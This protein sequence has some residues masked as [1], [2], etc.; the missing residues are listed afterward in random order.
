MLA[1]LRYVVRSLLRNRG[2]TLVTVLTLALGIGSAGAIFSATDWILFRRSQM[3]EDVYMVGGQRDKQA[4][5]PVRLGFMV[6]AYQEAMPGISALEVAGNE[7]GNVVVEGQPVDTNWL[8]VSP[9]LLPMLGITTWRGRGFV[10]GDAVAGSDQVIVVSNK[11][12]KEHLGGREDA[13]GRKVRVGDSIC[14]IIGIL[15]EGQEFPPFL[16]RGVYRPLIFHTDPAQPWRYQYFCLARLA[17]GFTREQAQEALRT[18]KFDLPAV[19]RQS[20][21]TDQVVLAGLSE[22][23]NQYA[24]PEIYRMLLAAVGCL[25]GIACLN[26]SNLM[27]VRMLGM[28]RELGIRLALGGGRFHIVRLLLLEGIALAVGSA[29]LGLLV[30]NWIFPLLLTSIGGAGSLVVQ[31]L[32]GSDLAGGNWIHWTLGW[33]AVGVMA[34][35]TALTGLMI[36]VVPALRVL[37]TDINAGLKEGGMVLG[38]SRGL[39]RFRGTLVMLQAAFAVILLAGAG[40]MIRTFENFRKVDL[41][42]NPD[43]LI[44]LA[45]GMPP[46]TAD[47]R[48]WQASLTRWRNLQAEIQHEPG[49]RSVGFGQDVVL[50]GWYYPSVD[51]F[52]PGDQTVKAAMGNFNIGYQ[53]TTGIRLK[54]GRWLDQSQGA[55]ILVNESLARTL[56]PGMENPIGQFVRMKDGNSSAHPELKGWEVVGVVADIRSTMRDPPGNYIYSPEAWGAAAMNTFV[57]RLGREYNPAVADALRRRIYA[58]DPQIVVYWISSI[59][60]RR[61][62]MLWAED[63][64]SSVLRVLAAIA[65][66]LAIVGVFAVMA[67]AVDRRMNEFGVRMA[68]GAMPGDLVKLV[69]GRGLALMVVG[70][71]LGLGG[72]M[73][74]G[75]F[76]SSLLFETSPLDPWVL[77]GVAAVLLAAAVLACLWPARRAAQVDVSRLLRSE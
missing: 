62:Q 76:L 14:V 49:V 71:M 13:L 42:F 41:G 48:D 30:A 72:A 51:L 23:L 17:P 45:I 50:P 66:L 47:G 46:R 43:R 12:W 64:A 34:G 54:R 60:E 27:L 35:L 53:E 56:W 63:K 2:F 22:L 16:Y 4:F 32:R 15:K 25:F 67:Y 26:A 74:L 11:F 37:R 20:M 65:L 28:R 39:A 70:L 36:S 40:L 5:T 57:V 1:D 61:E 29:V 77:G 21:A 24:R 75:R 33:R 10:T 44:K 7:S 73:A 69:M 18:A 31:A 68:L 59:D 38:E 55:A 52:G 9:N 19:F 8:D 6:R 3:P 58:Y